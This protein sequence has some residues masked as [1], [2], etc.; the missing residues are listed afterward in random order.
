MDGKIANPVTKKIMLGYIQ[1]SNEISYKPIE[2][3]FLNAKFVKMNTVNGKRNKITKLEVKLLP[4]NQILLDK[5]A[6]INL[7]H[8]LQ[9]QNPSNLL[10]LIF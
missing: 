9:I 8:L 3:I 6:F 7:I 4:N 2:G 1:I 5:S 10:N